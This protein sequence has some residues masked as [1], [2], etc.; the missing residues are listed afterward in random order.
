MKK[1][2]VAALLVPLTALAQ[3]G[4]SV[5]PGGPGQRGMDPKQMERME[6]K[7]RLARALGL[8]EALDLE[9]QKALEL[10][11]QLEKIDAKRVPLRAQMRD[12]RDVLRHAA[13][14]E[15]VPAQDVDQAIQK[16]LD[17]RAQ[18]AQVDRES[19]SAVTKGL[20]PDQKARA[21]L[22]LDRFQRRFAGPG[23]GPR[24]DMKV[25]RKRMPGAG[26]P[27]AGMEMERHPGMAFAWKSGS[28]PDRRVMAFSGGP[29][30]DEVIE[31][32][33]DMPFDDAFET[34]VE[35]ESP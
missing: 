1:L 20:N 22:F 8:A 34:E 28:G 3:A 13:D 4:G 9:P 11:Q 32:S 18:M 21:V 33:P 2:A 12:S 29:G 31:L 5:P 19:I 25:I 15:K 14:G 26:G 17:A 24:S 27:G 10:S 23:F 7:M 35:I 16:G 30:D 6:R